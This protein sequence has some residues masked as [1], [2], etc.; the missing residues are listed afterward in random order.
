MLKPLEK[1]K[2]ADLEARILIALNEICSSVP[3][4]KL[5][6]SRREVAYLGMRPDLVIDL[7]AGERRWEWIV[8]C[9]LKAQPK[10]L[11][12][13]LPYLQSV[14]E[15]PSDHG[16]YAIL[17]TPFLSEESRRLCAETG[18][19]YVDLAGNVRLSFDQVYIERRAQD[20]P[21]REKRSLR[22]LFSAKAGR[23]LRVLLTPPLRAWKVKELEKAA[24][25]SLGQV[26]NVRKLLLEGEWAE[27]AEGGLLLS[28]P[29]ALTRA[30]LESYE[31][32]LLSKES[33]YTMLEGSE[34]D[35][36]LRTALKESGDG[37]HA[38]L[39]SYSAARWF[40]PYTRQGTLYLY[41]DR[42]GKEI[43]KHSLGLRAVES[44][45]NV[46]LLEPRED[47]V[48][49]GR[50]EASQGLWCSSLVQTWLDLSV[51]GERGAEAA[52]VLFQQK[53]AAGWRKSAR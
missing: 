12:N 9:K 8:E 5:I 24:G 1:L 25:V 43:L 21:F 30:W 47:D 13:V 16:R 34:L 32:A 53:L 45:G 44:G 23:V 6:S 10:E 39:A 19:G 48:F 22:S 20:N 11:R 27:V 35:N 31:P 29:E 33:C 17:A 7:S 46:V 37:A 18:I 28:K 36:A 42:A 49:S 41:A 52:E 38:V 2:E 14:I 50:V 15:K 26:S 51:A 4:L 40:A 3:F